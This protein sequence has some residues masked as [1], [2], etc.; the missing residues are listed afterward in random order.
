[1]DP[2][3]TTERITVHLET[4]QERPD[5]PGFGPLAFCASAATLRMITALT[6]ASQ[7]QPKDLCAMVSLNLNQA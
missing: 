3:F 7:P 2:V 1:M 6:L 4:W 5:Q